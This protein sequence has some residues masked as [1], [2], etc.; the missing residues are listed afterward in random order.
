MCYPDTH[1][2]KE[3]RALNKKVG[4]LVVIVAIIIV[5]AVMVMRRGQPS[6]PAEDI[7]SSDVEERASENLSNANSAAK[8]APGGNDV[9]PPPPP[10]GAALAS[11]VIV[12]A[13]GFAPATSTVAR[14]ATVR[15]LN[16]DSAEH[17]VASAPHPT[18]TIYPPLNGDVLPPGASFDVKFSETGTVKYHDHLN[19]GLT[20]SVIVSE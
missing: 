15:F 11:E 4:I 16:A 6:A 1:I 12:S 3:V 17:Q 2:A 14:G 13:T 19:P 9:L 10:A 5:A 8:F 20:G 18:H 7:E